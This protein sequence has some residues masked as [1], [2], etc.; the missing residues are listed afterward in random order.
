M[1]TPSNPY[2][3]P[4]PIPGQYIT[5]TTAPTD[6]RR[7][8]YLIPARGWLVEYLPRIREGNGGDPNPWIIYGRTPTAYA[9]IGRQAEQPD[10]CVELVP[11]TDV[12]ARPDRDRTPELEDALRDIDRHITNVVRYVLDE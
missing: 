4:A 7:S 9:V 6:P 12:H 1:T 11:V 2:S 10:G 8:L 5:T 3:E